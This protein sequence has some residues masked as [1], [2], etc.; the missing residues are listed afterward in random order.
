MSKML[1][2]GSLLRPVALVLVA[3][4]SL[5]VADP[6][7]VPLGRLPSVARPSA[8]RLELTVDPA[9]ARFSGHTEIDTMLT[10]ATRVI[11][12]HGR[13]LQ[14]SSA[15]VRTGA[16][17]LAAQYTQVDD[18]GVV[19]LD[20]PQ[21]LPAGEV[22]LSFDYTAAFRSGAE[23]LFHARVDGQWYAWTQMESIDARRV[24][25]GFDE[26]GF[27]TPFTVSVRSP[28]GAKV[29]A[30][31]PEVAAVRSG[32]TRVHRFA[33]TRP[34]P[35]YLVAIVVG[36]FDVLETTVP[37][38]EVRRQPLPMRVIATRGQ[39]PRMQLAAAE[40]PKLLGLLEAYLGI[41]YPYEKL[42]LAASPIQD[43][44]M[45]N[46]GLILFEDSELLLDPKPRLSQL[47]EFATVAAH[48]MSHQWFGDLVTPVWW[49]DIWLNESFAE[50][51]GNKIASQ[52]RGDLDI[53]AVQLAEA[54]SAMDTDAL[55][56]GRPIRQEITANTQIDSAFDDI[57]YL[58]GAQVL[59]MFESYLGPEKLK[60]GVRLHLR[61][62][63]YGNASAEDFFRSLAKAA[64]DPGIV[65]ALRTFTDQ[66]GVP[67]ITV[68]DAA[69]GLRLT[70]ERYQPL[71]VNAPASQL[72]S[73]PVCLSRSGNR[74]CTLLETASA[75]IP[76]LAGSGPLVPNSD[77][78]GYY[79]FRL[80]EAGWS[81]MIAAAVQL[82]VREAMAMG[83]SLWAD[84]AAGTGT[85]ARVIAGARALAGHPER[86]AAIELAQPLERLARSALKDEEMAG[87]QRLMDSIYGPRLAALGLDL[88][89]GAYSNEPA[90]AQSLRQSLVP[91]VAEEARDAQVR[92]QLAN[93]AVAS[94]DGNAGAL[95]DA[96]RLTALSVAVQ[97]RGR[98]FMVQ[99]KDALV[100]SSDPLFRQDAA[101]ALGSADTPVLAAAALELAISPQ[102]RSAEAVRILSYL[103]GQPG[104]RDT[105]LAF[106]NDNIER[107][108]QLIPSSSRAQ[109]VPWL[110]DSDCSESD[111]EKVD[112][113]ARSK[114]KLLGDAQLELAKTKER[115][116]VCAALRHAKGAEIAA[117]L[118][119]PAGASLQNRPHA[120][121]VGSRVDVTGH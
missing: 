86:L 6:S 30:N 54:F 63:P 28:A 20:L 98:P 23:G 53:P 9:Q 25:P 65:P 103:T 99:L 44:A 121:E 107:V 17:I 92:T 73:I 104:A 76:S 35:T 110:F 105:V 96:F 84:F 118:N 21:E 27:K 106:V 111:I 2:R 75:T 55:G 19:R 62:Y 85:F 69:G 18:S 64:G 37:P 100:K 66:T 48:E 7:Q 11:F 52:W 31:A 39:K 58:K 45:E 26:P 117:A 109:L 67:F 87:Y 94:L 82:P 40:A 91:L 114:L 38:N 3:W 50:W 33:P 68:R 80:D 43:G 4:T 14:V 57:T 13:D 97:D 34:L 47:R 10:A 61:S 29:F 115:I 119:G 24:F 108:S 88:R 79:R 93:A 90:L 116:G 83:D 89:R 102:L 8:Y 51:M 74:T 72:W 1:S 113:W 71:G 95:D 112:A 36:P 41:P 16:S 12:L 32:G 49:T 101:A 78:A 46:A 56:H 120:N 15:Q 60:E 70:Q 22:T 81:R 77:G 5:V 59:S 42:D